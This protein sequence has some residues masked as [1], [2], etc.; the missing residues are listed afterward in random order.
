MDQTTM[1]TAPIPS[2]GAGSRRTQVERREEAERR[3]LDAAVTLIA[4]KGFSAFVLADVAEAAG[5]S[6]GLPTHYFRTKEALISRAADW[7]VER[8]RS[9]VEERLTES[10][11]L[12]SV[13]AFADHYLEH[14]EE[15]P[16][17]ARALSRILAEATTSNAL[18]DFI[19]QLNERTVQRLAEALRVGQAAGD[20]SRDID[21]GIQGTLILGLMRGVVG[22][23]LLD[24]SPAYMQNVRRE[25]RVQLTR[26]LHP[27]GSLA[28]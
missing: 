27:A 21:P 24:P 7:I 5:Y 6:R 15:D 1:T 28:K 20:V 26:A 18:G 17:E 10:G 22:Q 16:A 14:A 13:L 3:M 19:R 8:F 12:G 4:E 11:G 2:N 23:W 25:V 9:R